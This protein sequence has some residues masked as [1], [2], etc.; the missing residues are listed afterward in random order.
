M[1]EFD[2]QLTSIARSNKPI[3]DKG[4]KSKFWVTIDEDEI[5]VMDRKNIYT[6]KK[7][8]HVNKGIVTR[9]EKMKKELPNQMKPLVDTIR[10]FFLVEIA[11]KTFACSLGATQAK[12][13]AKIAID[14]EID[15]GIFSKFDNLINKAATIKLVEFVMKYFDIDKSYFDNL[16]YNRESGNDSSRMLNSILKRIDDI[17]KN[18]K[19]TPQGE[20]RNEEKRQ[21]EKDIRGKG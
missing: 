10:E 13:S 14:S 20:F 21:G 9:S 18:I 6:P 2:K 19:I 7:L 3:G 15:E 1:N 17:P 12:E 16:A 8:D 11:P 4:Y 5:E